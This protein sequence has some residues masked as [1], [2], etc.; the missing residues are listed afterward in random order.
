[1]F[2]LCG[3]GLLSEWEVSSGKLISFTSLISNGNIK[4]GV[5]G[6][7]SIA[8]YCL[9]TPKQEHSELRIYS[10]KSKSLVHSTNLDHKIKCL[11]FEGSVVAYSSGKQIAV[12]DIS[13][14]VKQPRIIKR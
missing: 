4:L 14:K 11:V 1:M 8:L 6:G 13:A 7:E 10:L 12:L 2:A 9:A 5:F 3:K